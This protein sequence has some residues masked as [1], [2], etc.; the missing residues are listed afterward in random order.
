MRI[1]AFLNAGWGTEAVLIAV[2]GFFVV[3]LAMGR[4]G[5]SG[6]R[7]RQSCRHPGCT[8][9]NP[10]GARFCRRCGRRLS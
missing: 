5:G 2:V 6:T 3:R 10:V 7:A 8:A 9:E 1:M 4:A